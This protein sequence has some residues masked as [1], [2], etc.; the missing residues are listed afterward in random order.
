[1]PDLGGQPIA[2]IGVE[3]L[4]P[5]R[6]RADGTL[7]LDWLT[8]D[9]APTVT[10]GRP[11]EGG[12]IWRRAWV[13]GVDQF[14]GRW[15]EDYR[16]VQN[17]GTGLLSQ[18]TADW[19]DYHAE[20]T[21]TPHLATSAGLAVR[22]QGLRRYYAL[23]LHREGVARLVRVCDGE[24]VLAERQFAWDFGGTY[25]CAIE[26][27]GG[28]LRGWIDGTEVFDVTDEDGRLVGGGVALV[29]EEGCLGA[30]AVRVSGR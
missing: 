27:V 7:F 2:E 13:D 24:A 17:H 5:A 3:V 15:P 19:R 10:L 4:A 26:V 6:G 29:C 23:M 30:G 14:A 25:R 11:A 21:L 1:M 8:W 22:A 18:G 12:T 9:G 16:I 20:A 28:R